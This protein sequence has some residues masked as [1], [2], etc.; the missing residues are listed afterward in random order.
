M[1]PSNG[2]PMRFGRSSNSSDHQFPTNRHISRVHVTAQYQPPSELHASS[3]ILVKCLGWNGA[4][5]RCGGQLYELDKGDSWVSTQPSAEIMLD[6]MDCRVMLKWPISE[7]Q[8]SNSVRSSSAWTEDFSPPRRVFAG[9]ENTILPSSPP[10]MRAPSPTSPPI[11]ARRNLSSDIL[12][13]E[14]SLVSEHTAVH[15]YE[16]DN[17]DHAYADSESPSK[18]VQTRPLLREGSSMAS[19][20]SSNA[21]DLSDQENENEENDPVVHSFGPYG[22]NL[23]NRLDSFSHTSPLQPQLRKKKVLKAVPESP[24][25]ESPVYSK[26][27][28]PTPKRQI[29][30]SPVKNHVVNQLAFSRVHAMPLSLIH[31]NLPADLKTCTGLG[32]DEDEDLTDEDLR[33]VLHA[34]PCVGEINRQGKD[35][36]GK[37][38]ENEFYYVP[39]MD[40]NTMRRDAVLGGRGGTGLRSVRKNHKVSLS[41]QCLLGR[42]DFV[43][44]N[45]IGKNHVSDT[46][47]GVT[48]TLLDHLT[49]TLFS[50]I[51]HDFRFECITSS[52]LHSPLWSVL[53]H[54]TI[55]PIPK[56]ISYNFS[57]TGIHQQS[58]EVSKAL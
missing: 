16:D 10:A 9:L 35:A 50:T 6:V 36:A 28:D 15:V 46:F 25:R 41:P 21:D 47:R 19:F 22:S 3:S 57:H 2:E 40:D 51:Y 11:S 5:V 56:R 29:Q 44:S 30:E 26:R 7:Q 54:R 23:L 39:E 33:R 45:T 55:H 20:S 27:L 1:V 32:I 38:L 24:K 17:S 48:R 53:A 4:K 14:A 12:S 37:P 8:R 49:I 18:C 42:T 13:S 58:N 34:I 43:N 52:H 31:S